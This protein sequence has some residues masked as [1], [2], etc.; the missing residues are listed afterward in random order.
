MSRLV[1]PITATSFAQR[2]AV[3]H[4]TT[5]N[6]QQTWDTAS[7]LFSS[8]LC[9]RSPCA[10]SNEKKPHHGRSKFAQSFAPLPTSFPLGFF[11]LVVIIVH[12]C[13]IFSSLNPSTLAHI[14]S[15][16]GGELE[17]I[18]YSS[19]CLRFYWQPVP[20]GIVQLWPDD[21]DERGM[22]RWMTE[23]YSCQTHTADGVRLVSFLWPFSF[24]YRLF[25]SLK[26]NALESLIDCW[27][28]TTF[29]TKKEREL[30]ATRLSLAPGLCILSFFDYAA[31]TAGQ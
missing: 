30:R 25:S 23:G 4:T 15:E 3:T 24:F 14:Q 11:F 5:Q 8:P 16:T 20:C 7:L 28:W 29:L 2:S 19:S 26:R 10:F 9:T 12:V 18:I 17:A 1:L 21:S 6:Q 27:Y 13:V 31:L 22:S